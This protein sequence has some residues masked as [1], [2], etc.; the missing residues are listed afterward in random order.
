MDTFSKIWL[1][2]VFIL[3]GYLFLRPRPIPKDDPHWKKSDENYKRKL[4][5]YVRK[6]GDEPRF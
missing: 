5:K 6:Q 4:R 2:V 3:L 1:A